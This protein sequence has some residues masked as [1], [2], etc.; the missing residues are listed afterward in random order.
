MRNDLNLLV[1]KHQEKWLAPTFA[2]VLVFLSGIYAFL[3]FNTLGLKEKTVQVSE[4]FRV[5]NELDLLLSAVKDAE[6]SQRGFI[7]TGESEYLTPYNAAVARIDNREKSLRQL[8]ADRPDLQ[9]RLETYERLMNERLRLLRERIETF[10]QSG[11][12]T[13]L[14]QFRS[15]LGMRAME[16]LKT[17]HDGFRED[18]RQNYARYLEE[19]NT[20]TGLVGTTYLVAGIVTFFA[21]AAAFFVVARILRRQEEERWIKALVAH[22]SHLIG[23]D[24]DTREIGKRVNEFFAEHLGSFVANFYVSSAG[25]ARLTATYAGGGGPNEQSAPEVLRVGERLVGEVL[26]SKTT[27]VIEDVPAG[28]LPI[29]SSTGCSDPREIVIV[30][31]MFEDQVTGLLEFGVLEKIPKPK[32]ALINALSETVGIYLNSA[33]NRFELQSLLRNSQEQARELASQKARLIESNDKLEIQTAE[34]TAAKEKLQIQQ[35]EL[36]QS[37]EELEQQAQALEQQ[38]KHLSQSNA[39]LLGI[40]KA[41]EEKASELILASKYKSEFLANMSHEL[42]TPLN[43]ML[44]LSTLLIENKEENLTSQQIDFVKTIHTA[45]SDLLN[46]INDILDLS[47]VEAGKLDLSPEWFNLESALNEVAAMFEPQAS[48]KDL[49]LTV[50][51]EKG[52]PEEIYSDRHRLGQILKN[53]VSNAIKFTD[54]GGVTLRVRPLSEQELS[55]WVT[56]SSHFAI[57]II[58][59][60]IGIPSEMK[61]RIFEAF[62]QVD[63]STSR[64][65]GGTGLGLAISRELSSLLG[66][67]IRVVSEPG[68]GSVFTLI[69]PVEVDYE[70]AEASAKHNAEAPKKAARTD[71]S[72]GPVEKSQALMRAGA[73]RGDSSSQAEIASRSTVFDETIVPSGRV[74]LIVED[75]KKFARV[76]SM[77]AEQHGFSPVSASDAETALELIKK[78]R[79]CAIVLDVKLPGMSGI[80]LLEKLKQNPRT[81]HIPIHVVSGHDC[82]PNALRIG[83]AGF[84]A[85]PASKEELGEAFSRIEA[86]ISRRC[87]KVL[88]VEDDRIQRE[89]ICHLISGDDIEIVSAEKGQEAMELLRREVFDCMILDLKLPDMSGFEL[90]SKMDSEEGISRPPV[91][92]YTGRDLEKDE[93]FRLRKYSDSI[94][95]KGARSPERLL[96]EVTLFLHRVETDLPVDKQTMLKKIRKQGATFAGQKVLIVDDDVRNIFALMSAL[97]SHGL[98]V[99]VGRNGQEAIEYLK[100]DPDVDLVL[101]DIMMPKMDGYEAMS[102][103]RNEMSN[104]KLPIIALTAKAMKG[105]SEKCIEA[106]ASDYLPKPVDLSRLMSLLN[107]WLPTELVN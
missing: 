33:L 103:I 87:K 14:S 23:G 104:S 20:R 89:G 36:R 40:K 70:P 81:R 27:K 83:A 80:S 98:E 44:I 1:R 72:L 105:D 73:T 79:P 57:D 7:V 22:M 52:I 94:V 46:V 25:A 32:M 9:P 56:G 53:F 42:R 74:I 101:M 6:S 47:K 2:A 50:A 28:Y 51:I 39:D 49:D 19:Y 69:T 82:L 34:L 15:G 38:K 3:Y 107:A 17:F 65:H 31:F 41:L 78:H 62:Q 24:L 5:M 97:E 85:K 64:K 71:A 4:S 60:G 88:V 45:G 100:S 11:R 55:P 16:R 95:L 26:R 66:G 30:P 8:I 76:M 102:Y 29:S 43:S 106:G 37:N 48:S 54:K 35:E 96:D 13:A 90:L 21:L 75:D 84:L 61:A 18:E 63:G 86:I 58:D 59:T 99:A 77:V 12:D 67:S 91:I 93:E 92:V 68:K 10:N